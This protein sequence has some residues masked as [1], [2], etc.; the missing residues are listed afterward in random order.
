MNQVYYTK[1]PALI[2]TTCPSLHHHLK[3]CLDTP[4]QFFS[5]AIAT[6]TNCTPTYHITPTTLPN[7]YSQ[8]RHI[9]LRKILLGWQSFIC[10][11]HDVSHDI[12]GRDNSHE[13]APVHV[14]HWQYV[15]PALLSRLQLFCEYIP[16]Q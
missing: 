13:I 11:L 15:E 8:V 4:T 14:H 6:T 5:F 16:S 12:L 3:S 10:L 7:S 9:A 2:V 1:D